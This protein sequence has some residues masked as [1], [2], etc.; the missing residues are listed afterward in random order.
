LQKKVII[1]WIKA[2]AD[3]YDCL[4][5]A[6]DHPPSSMRFFSLTI[7]AFTSCSASQSPGMSS[8]P[9][10]KSHLIYEYSSTRKTMTAKQN[11]LT[12]GYTS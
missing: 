7:A 12:S 9:Q 3:L 5:S 1:R 2:I 4:F 8:S 11:T 6:H 10:L